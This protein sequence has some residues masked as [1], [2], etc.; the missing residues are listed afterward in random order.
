MKKTALLFVVV[1]M[2][3]CNNAS[4]EATTTPP[5]DTAAVAAPKEET[6]PPPPPMDSAA[7]MKKWQECMTPGEMHKWMASMNGK[8]TTEGK[9]WMDEK[10]PPTESKGTC[11]NKMVLNGLYQESVHK[12]MMMGMPFE[13]H[14]TLAY[15]INRKVFISTWIDNM[16]SSIMI[17]EGTYDDASKTLTLKGPW[18]DPIKGK[19]EIRETCKMINDK[20]QMMEMY[21]I[22]GG[23]EMKWMEIKLAKK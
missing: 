3:G 13:G 16:G 17:L 20:T 21:G 6:P 15:D 12:S 10:A 19:M 2:I 8:W 23:K 14:G 5:V 22:Q 1:A 7:M 18:E 4:N 9:F 11:E